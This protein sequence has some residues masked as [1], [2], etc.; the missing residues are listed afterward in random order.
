MEA[1]PADAYLTSYRLCDA[2][3]Y[4]VRVDE[5]LHFPG[6]MYNFSM[7]RAVEAKRQGWELIKHLRV[8]GKCDKLVILSGNP[9]VGKSTWTET[10]GASEPGAQTTVFYDDLLNNRRRRAQWWEGFRSA[11]L[12][13]PVEA[14]VVTRSMERAIASNEARGEKGGHLVPR[15]KILQYAAEFE[16]ASVAE[17]FTRVR[18]FEN[19]FDEATGEGGF[20]LRHEEA[21]ER[22]TDSS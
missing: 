11:K 4:I 2:P 12:D 20:T 16:A 3:P 10:M 19:Q 22:Q 6:S 17:G 5:F 7:P 21:A 13:V 1:I 18:I 8:Q 9:A 14:V 15:E